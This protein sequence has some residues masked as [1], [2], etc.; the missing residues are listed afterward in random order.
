MF[1]KAL[2]IASRVNELTHRAR[3]MARRDIVEGRD[4][5]RHT[6]IDREASLHLLQ[7]A[8]NL[9]SEVSPAHQQL[10]SCATYAIIA[11]GKGPKSEIRHLEMLITLS[12]NRLAALR[13]ETAVES[14]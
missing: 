3:E 1:T 7:G 6:S 2:K 5:A 11:E 12:S 10:V 4:R 9:L 14:A 8:S 13:D